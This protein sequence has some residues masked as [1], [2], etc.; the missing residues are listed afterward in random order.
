V[1]EAGIPENALGQGWLRLDIP[2]RTEEGLSVEHTEES[3]S[4]R[5]SPAATAG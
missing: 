5:I 1:G 3:I 2:F 4:T